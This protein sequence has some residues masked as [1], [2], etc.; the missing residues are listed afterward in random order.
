M[1]SFMVVMPK[2][3]ERPNALTRRCLLHVIRHG[4][5]TMCGKCADGW[6]MPF[7]GTH[8]GAT[9]LTIERI[10]DDRGF[11]RTCQ[12]VLETQDKAQ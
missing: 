11:C 4:D 9:S 2:M 1:D 3:R 10:L 6:D 5:I 8:N 12:R 7:R